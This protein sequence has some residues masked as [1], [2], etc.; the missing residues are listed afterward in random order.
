MQES[1]ITVRV[2][3]V[4]KAHGLKG[5]VGLILHTDLPNERLFK[6]A[7]L[8]VESEEFDELTVERVRTQQGRWFVKFVEIN[9]RSA[10]ESLRDAILNITLDREAEFNDDPDAWYP[11]ELKG[12]KVIT[13]TGEN[14]GR[15][16]DL[17]NYPAQDV[18]LIKPEHAEPVMLPFVAQFVPEINLEEQFIVATPPGG[19]FDPENLASE[20]D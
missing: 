10:A 9:D 8:A 17:L 11:S 7:V 3:S 18:L 6:G 14:L 19:L 15:V 2:G 20:R 1:S 12:L 4:G 16:I 5:E 13:E